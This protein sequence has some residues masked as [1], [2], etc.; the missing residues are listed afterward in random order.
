M[1]DGKHRHG[2]LT[3]F[4]IV[5]IILNIA[6][7]LFYLLGSDLV[8]ANQPN[9]PRWALP[10]LA[11]IG[12]CNVAFFIALFFWKKWAF[13]AF[14]GSAIFTF[15]VNLAIGQNAVT[16]ILGL[17]GVAVLYGVLQI[18]GP[19]KGWTQLE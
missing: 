11:I 5:G 14:I 18:G 8:T 7:A 2:C 6:T 3:A 9:L 19:N 12:L 17:C 13:Y 16:A 15:I 1:T 4:L 10:A